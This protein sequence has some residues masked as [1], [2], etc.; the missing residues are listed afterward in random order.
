[1][2]GQS[3]SKSPANKG[4]QVVQFRMRDAERIAGAV[5]AYETAVRE[6]SPSSLP[7]AFPGGA[8]CLLG[9]T[10]ASWSKG[11][12]QNITIYNEGVPPSETAGET[13]I[14]DVWNKFADI[15]ANKWVMFTSFNGHYYVIAAECD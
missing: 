13:T 9:K 10:T 6:S 1:M 7:R 5:Q 4:D 8:K 3:K 15:E 2:F 12:S 11:T 14:E